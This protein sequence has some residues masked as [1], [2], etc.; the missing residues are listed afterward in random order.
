M[1]KIIALAMLLTGFLGAG[2]VSARSATETAAA[3]EVVAPWL[4]MTDSAKYGE[5]WDKGGAMMQA[6][7]TKAQWE[8]ALAQV[9]TPLGAVKERTLTSA[10]FTKTLPGA[11]E[12][13]YVVVTYATSFEN[14]PGMTETVI[15]MKDKDGAWRVS[16]YFIK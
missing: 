11:P 3:Q 9:R 15:P 2:L 8:A 5:S 13:E 4:A 1:K 6:V 16:G 12:G 10:R 14:K 7:V